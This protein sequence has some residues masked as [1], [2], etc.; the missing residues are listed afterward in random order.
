[1]KNDTGLT[2]DVGNPVGWLAK[3]SDVPL[4]VPKQRFDVLQLE[5]SPGWHENSWKTLRPKSRCRQVRFSAYGLAFTKHLV[6]VGCNKISSRQKFELRV[7]RLPPRPGIP[8]GRGG[9]MAGKQSGSKGS[10]SKRRYSPEERARLVEEFRS[11]GLNQREFGERSGVPFQTLSGLGQTQAGAGRK[12][13]GPRPADQARSLQ[14][15]RAP[16][17]CRG[18]PEERDEPEGLR[19]GLGRVGTHDTPEVG[20][21]LRGEGPAGAGAR[22]VRLWR[23]EARPPRGRR[24]PCANGS[25]R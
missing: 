24:S 9:G 25:R 3:S 23:Q 8:G 21:G 2:I 12:A 15:G 22:N 6:L 11:S 20:P 14:P 7:V 18:V 19:Q 16:A 10:G 13:E 4:Q 1:M 17:G 5:K